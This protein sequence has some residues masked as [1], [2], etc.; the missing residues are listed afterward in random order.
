MY[1]YCS[2]LSLTNVGKEKMNFFFTDVAVAFVKIRE[3]HIV[4]LGRVLSKCSKQF[5]DLKDVWIK[6]KPNSKTVFL[7]KMTEI[8]QPESWGT[9]LNP[10]LKP[11]GSMILS[12]LLHFSEPESQGLCFLT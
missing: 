1:L 10:V 2:L 9:E 4:R 3:Q 11:I 6:F 7:L 5:T 12:K 8:W